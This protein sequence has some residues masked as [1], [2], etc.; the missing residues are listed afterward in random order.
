MYPMS[1]KNYDVES[2]PL[3]EDYDADIARLCFNRAVTFIENNQQDDDPIIK[4]QVLVLK[5]LL[6]RFMNNDTRGYIYTSELLAHIRYT[7][8]GDS[9]R[10]RSHRQRRKSCEAEQFLWQ[11]YRAEL[12][13]KLVRTVPE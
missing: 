7:S 2:S 1:Y 5:Y 6:F 11:A 3:A 10:L 4:V 8:L 9:S 13:G 12:L